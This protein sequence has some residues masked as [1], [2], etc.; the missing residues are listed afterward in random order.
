MPAF[1]LNQLD[2][3]KIQLTGALNFDTVPALRTQ[4]IQLLP[5]LN[6]IVVDLSQVNFCD[7]SGVALM[8][9]CLRQARSAQKNIIFEQ[10]PKQM[11]AIAK[12]TGV[13]ELLFTANEEVVMPAQAGIQK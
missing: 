9:E 7:S 8:L 6:P 2:S 10:A 4:L 5:A 13:A 12:M 1:T 11:Q 3:S